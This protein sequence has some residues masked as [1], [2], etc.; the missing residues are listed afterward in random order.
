MPKS[1]SF[2]DFGTPQL[3]R[4]GE[5]ATRLGEVVFEDREPLDLLDPREVRVDRVDLLLDLPPQPRI[6]GDGRRIGREPEPVREL[7]ALVGIERQHRHEVLTVIA[8]DDRFGDV[9]T[10]T[11]G[12]LDVDRSDVLAARGDDQVLLAAGD[13]QVPIVAQGSEIA[14]AQPAVGRKHLRGRSH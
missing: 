10:V 2:S 5:L 13:G 1:G 3:E 7:A 11:E 4:G 6:G 14:G 8:V 12:R 9:A